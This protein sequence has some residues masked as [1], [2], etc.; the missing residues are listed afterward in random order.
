[1]ARHTETGELGAGIGAGGAYHDN[2]GGARS[3]SVSSSTT[4]RSIPITPRRC[5]S[6]V[7]LDKDFSFVV[8]IGGRRPGVRVSSI[9][10]TPSS[11]RCRTAVTGR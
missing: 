7:F 10:S 9:L 6:R 4:L 2:G 8:S 5:W 3:A 1:M 11:R